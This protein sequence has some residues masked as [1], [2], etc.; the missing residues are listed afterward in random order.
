MTKADI[1]KSIP[2]LEQLYI[3]YS[4][5]THLPYMERNSELLDNQIYA[6]TDEAPA[7]ERAR[8][9]TAEDKRASIAVKIE[10]Q[11][12]LKF[13]S[14]LYAYGADALVFQVGENYY[15]TALNEIVRRPDFSNLPKNQHPLLNP[16]LQLSMIYYMQEFRRGPETADKQKI[17]EL[18]R[19]MTLLMMR[20]P[21][22][23]PL[24]E[25]QNEDGQKGLQII[26]IKAANGAPMVPIFSDAVEYNHF[27][28]NQNFKASLTD[29]T[30]M[31]KMTLPQEIHG[32]VINPASVGLLIPNDY[33]HSDSTQQ[34]LQKISRK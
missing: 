26:Y 22:L 8:T 29:F 1:I 33:I 5:L 16:G 4:G 32:F 18:A 19:K 21:Y 9:L 15:R 14:E 12:R 17:E 27:K 7:I 23:V 11:N 20:S 25:S 28:G 30:K 3:I 13:F 24:K 10:K 6:F 34:L 2:N 31:S